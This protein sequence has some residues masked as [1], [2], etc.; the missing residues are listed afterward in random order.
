MR[1]GDAESEWRPV[2]LGVPKGSILG[3]LL[4]SM[5]FDVITEVIYQAKFH[6]Y[7]EGLQ[8]FYHLP[9]KDANATVSLKKLE[10]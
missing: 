4:F 10:H 3:L 8:I 9:I 1:A 6:L 7:S 2:T 5:Y